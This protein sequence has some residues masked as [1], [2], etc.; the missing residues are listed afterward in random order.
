MAERVDK[1]TTLPA[2]TRYVTTHNAKGKSVYVN[3]PVQQFIPM[4]AISGYARTYAIAPIP[5]KLEHE[6]DLK[7]YLGRDATTSW[8][9]PSVVTPN[10][11]TVFVTELGP[12]AQSPMHRTVSIDVA[13]ITNGEVEH[14]LDGGETV[15]LKAGV[16][17]ICTKVGSN[18]E[19]ETARIILFNVLRITGGRILRAQNQLA[20]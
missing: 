19:H 15:R 2:Y 5:G 16:S 6:Q 18:T 8:S 11:A 17:S 1:V 10:G 20:S 12:G 14:E 13:V 4:S 9:Q 3:A 7:A